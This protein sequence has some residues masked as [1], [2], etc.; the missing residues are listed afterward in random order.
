[1]ENQLKNR[2]NGKGKKQEAT[3]WWRHSEG[4][5]RFEH[6]SC[7]RLSRTCSEL[8]EMMGCWLLLI[9]LVLVSSAGIRGQGLHSAGLQNLCHSQTLNSPTTQTTKLQSYY[10]FIW[11]SQLSY[12]CDY[13]CRPKESAYKQQGK[14][15]NTTQTRNPTNHKTA[16]SL[17]LYCCFGIR[18]NINLHQQIWIPQC[19]SE[20]WQG[21]VQG[22]R[23]R[24]HRSSGSHQ[25]VAKHFREQLT[26]AQAKQPDLYLLIPPH[27]LVAISVIQENYNF[28]HAYPYHFQLLPCFL[29]RWEGKFIFQLFLP[30]SLKEA[31]FSLIFFIVSASLPSQLSPA[32]VGSK[33]CPVGMA[34]GSAVGYHPWGSKRRARGSGG[35]KAVS[36]SFMEMVTPVAPHIMSLEYTNILASTVFR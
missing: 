22:T 18:E 29:C 24:L 23:A 17:L 26:E 4:W 13:N 35:Q 12:L 28:I 31:G 3:D 21:T 25:R 2:E 20:S 15:P 8:L 32:V 27:F 9:P 10:S 34:C 36:S 11:K 14:K 16:V 30:F 7:T 33:P 19:S 1:M 6:C 5:W